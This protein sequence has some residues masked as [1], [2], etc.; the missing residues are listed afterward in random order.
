[1]KIN[2]KIIIIISII[3]IVITVLG[4]FC[5]N[6]IKNMQIDKEKTLETMEMIKEQYKSFSPVVEEFTTK[7]ANFYTM[8][9]DKMYL[10]SIQENS[11]EILNFMQEYE[12]FVINIDSNNSYLKENCKRKYAD[13]RV[14]NTCNLFKQG[15]EAVMNYYITD[16]KVY[17]EFV[18][19]Y[20][21]WADENSEEIKL[22]SMSFSLYKDYIDYDQDGSYLGGK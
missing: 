7:R 14:N 19:S 21:A 15:Y 11:T 3:L 6:F 17:N 20:N 16:L 22:N 10:E 9:E 12:T 2:K 4:I 18:T 1:M 5:L 13:N 8:K